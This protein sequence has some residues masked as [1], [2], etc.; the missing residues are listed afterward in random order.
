M[1]DDTTTTAA[2]PQRHDIDERYTWRL[3]DIYAD[4][5]AWE[6]AFAETEQLL[7]QAG[8]YRGRLTDSAETLYDC[9]DLRSRVQRSVARLHQYAYLQKDLDNRVSAYQAMT[10]RAGM[11]ASRAGAAFSFVEPE[12][13]AV[14]D[15]RLTE[16]AARFPDTDRFD[17]YIRELIRS[18]PHVR[19]S[20]VEQLL[21]EAADLARGP[22]A[23]FRLLDN[24]DLTYPAITDEQGRTVRL[25]KQ[26]FARFMESTDRDVRRR[27]HDAFYSAY[28]DHVN[29]IG[30][31]LAAAVNRD[32]F[33]ARARRFG[34]SLEAALDGDNIPTAVY[35]SLIETTEAGLDGLHAYIGLRRRLLDLDRVRSYDLLCPLFPELHDDIPYDE[36]VQTVLDAVS[37]LGEEYTAALREAFNSRWVDVFETEGKGGGAY[38]YSTYDVHP[39][40]LMNY[41]DTLDNVFTLAHEMGHAMHSCLANRTQPFEKAQYAIFTAEV[42]S[43]LNEGLLLE[44]LLSRADDR[45]RAYL[46]T[47]F[48]DNTL[49]TF[50]NQVLYAHFELRIHEE[51]EQGRA[52]SPAMMNDL[53]RELTARYYGPDFEVDEMTPLKWARIPHFYRGFYVFQYATS[54]AASLAILERLLEG[55]P[56]MVERYLDL[57][58][59]GGRDHPIALLKECGVDMTAVEPVRAT[60]EMFARK[61]AQLEETV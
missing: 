16:L 50:F 31:M 9:L 56:G 26:R 10:E 55:Q 12:L 48:L 8:R 29:S 51:V 32:V 40:V 35:H 58:R 46:L 30:A 41:N 53:W 15:D 49:G 5:A 20:E 54:Y 17:F 2:L 28:R 19:S 37:P 24:A 6:D 52:L 47:R 23:I 60:L 38:S 22:G 11:L 1:T 21:A 3:S 59:S 18:R 7:A 36:A 44:H 43:T 33:F 14:S 42:A 25:T 57:L 13:L 61:V 39:F 45:R 27:A 4:D 34:S